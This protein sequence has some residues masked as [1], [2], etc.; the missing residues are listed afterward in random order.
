M[1][2]KT[3]GFKYVLTA[4][5]MCLISGNVW[6]EE[7]IQTF[8][9]L[10]VPNPTSA[11][12]KQKLIDGYVKGQIGTIEDWTFKLSDDSRHLYATSGNMQGKYALC[13]SNVEDYVTTPSF[14][15][16]VSKVSF[17]AKGMQAGSKLKIAYDS[18]FGWTDATEETITTTGKLYNFTFPT[19]IKAHKIK[20]YMSVKTS[21]ANVAIDNCSVIYAAVTS[22]VTSPTISPDSKTFE[23]SQEVTITPA[24][25]TTVYYTTNGNDPDN[26][27]T[28]HTEVVTFIVNSTT[29]VK[30][31]AY[32]EA[33]ASDIVSATY[34]KTLPAPTFAYSSE[35]VT[36]NIGEP[37]TAPTLTNTS[38]GKVTY[39]SSNTSLATVTADGTVTLV[40]NA[41]GTTT[42][43]ASVSETTNYGAATTSYT[44]TVIDPSAPSGVVLAVNY[45]DKWYA[46][47]QT[48]TSD[49]AEAVEI[50]VTNNEVTSDITGLGLTWN[51]E[52]DKFIKAENGQYL[53]YSGSKTN[54]AL[55]DNS[56]EW[57]FEK[58]TNDSYYITASTSTTRQIAYSN[59]NVFGTYANSNIN[60]SVYSF[61]IYIL[62]ISSSNKPTSN[63]DSDTGT[64]TLSGAWTAD[65]ITNLALDETVTSVDMTNIDMEA[66][67]TTIGNPNCLLYAKAG[68]A[69]EDLN[70]IGGDAAV[71]GIEL[72]DGYNF[73]NAKEFTG[74]ITYSRTFAE[75]WNTFALPFNATITA[76]D[77]IEEFDR[78]DDSGKKILFKKATSIIANTPYLIN[79]ATAGEKTFSANNV[80]VP[81]TAT[82]GSVYK[83]NFCKLTGDKIAGKYILVLENGKEV[84]APAT[85]EATLPA[86]RGYLELAQPT[87]MRYSISH[88]QGGATD[89][90]A[91]NNEGIKLYTENG[92]LNIHTEVAQSVLIR[93]IDGRTIQSIRLAKDAN[94]RI[95]GLAKGI[96]F[97]NHQ[98]VI[99]K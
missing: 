49:K 17:W 30:A 76:D 2:T 4:L 33:E 51:I 46:I 84:F 53:A 85:T 50:S 69:L 34:T 42:I 9:N 66:I 65:A 31:I 12:N 37:F 87:G 52:N 7:L 44:L 10:V 86:F 16:L 97:V 23:T 15:G 1:N 99:I 58:Q 47:N 98:K 35:S 88:D 19:P 26:T 82:T 67:P 74:D 91:A 56:Y 22:I 68:T 20:F 13:L 61:N 89:I 94:T 25:G 32:K 73:Y 27:L 95:N 59:S 70:I 80:T 92:I 29:T 57:I 36:L 60:N 21:S 43:T 83:N 72:Q 11:T 40:E 28:P 55:K 54:I 45:N 90:E 78:I 96:Y 48:I 14:E 6:G 18:G 71:I 41:S 5:L 81:V 79:I 64:M 38:D 24:E 75:G 8:D 39:S 77:Q 62:S 3:M 93:S 63:T